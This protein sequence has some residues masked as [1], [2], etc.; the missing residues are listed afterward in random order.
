M[1]AVVPSECAFSLYCC[2]GSR[3][4]SDWQA[5]V[6]LQRA[7]TTCDPFNLWARDFTSRPLSIARLDH[8]RKVTWL[9]SAVTQPRALPSAPIGIRTSAGD[10]GINQFHGVSPCYFC[11]RAQVASLGNDFSPYWDEY[12]SLRAVLLSIYI[13]AAES[14]GSGCSLGSNRRPIRLVQ[15]VGQHLLTWFR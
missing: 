9:L 4:T 5:I 7:T 13:A 15:P 1:L 12:N 10:V 8:L 2:R 6:K 14:S 11:F 3:L